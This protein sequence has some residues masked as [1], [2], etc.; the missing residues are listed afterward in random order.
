MDSKF[1]GSA[2][3]LWAELK[4]AKAEGEEQLYLTGLQT[5]QMLLVLL[6]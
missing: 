3:A 5:L 1:A 6:S 4:A 2:D